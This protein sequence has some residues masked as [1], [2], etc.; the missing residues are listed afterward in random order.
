MSLE[1]VHCED[2]KQINKV[3]DG[4]WKKIG[5]NEQL[6]PSKCNVKSDF[7]FLKVLSLLSHP[8]SLTNHVDKLPRKFHLITFKICCTDFICIP[9]CSSLISRMSLRRVTLHA[10]FGMVLRW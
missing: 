7:T 4:E 3:N 8:I 5:M 6:K 9:L 10:T 2:E 1:I